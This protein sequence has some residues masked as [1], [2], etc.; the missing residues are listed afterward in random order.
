[1]GTGSNKDH[2]GLLGMIWNPNYDTLQFPLKAVVI[3]PHVRFTKQQVLS[4]ASSTFDPIGFISPALAPAKTFISSLWDKGFDW[5]PDLPE[6]L[7]QQY[8]KIAT[9]IES[10]SKFLSLLIILDFDKA[11]PIEMHVF[12]DACPVTAA[13]CYVFFSSIWS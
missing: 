11:L 12:C 4:S 13:G 3:P 2:A 9:E 5:D 1:M 10:A 6:E 7:Q 8:N